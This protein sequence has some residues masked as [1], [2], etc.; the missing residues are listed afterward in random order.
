LDPLYKASAIFLF[1]SVTETQGLAV[2]EALAAGTPAVVV[3]G[4]GAPEAI[5]EGVNGF[6]VEN[7]PALMAD[8]ALRLL[9]DEPL[10][11]KMAANA[12]TGAAELTPDKVAGRV[13]R[14]Y[15]AL[16]D[17]RLGATSAPPISGGG[18]DKT[19]GYEVPRDT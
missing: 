14:L 13:I 17:E 7:E 15:E 19:P 8:R 9:A 18:E 3:N 12:R 2:G 1:P 6:V 4:G 5:Q 10:R 16:I 11:S